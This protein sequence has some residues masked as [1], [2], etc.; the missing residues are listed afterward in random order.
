MELT[1]HLG[2]LPTVFIVAI[3]AA[4]LAMT[5]GL[6]QRTASDVYR[7]MSIAFGVS[8]LFNMVLI[9]TS[10]RNPVQWG[11]SQATL[12]LLSFVLFQW[13][14]YRFFFPRKKKEQLY[15][16]IA[17]G[18]SIVVLLVSLFLSPELGILVSSLFSLTLTILAA[19]WV[20]PQYK[21]RMKF[22]LALILFLCAALLQIVFAVAGSSVI[23]LVACLFLAAHHFTMFLLLF[24][25]IMDVI[26]AISYTSKT[27]GLTGLFLKKY[28]I[29]KTQEAIN[30]GE[31]VA[32]I[33]SDIDNF[34]TLN[35]TQGHQ[36]GDIILKHVAKIMAEVCEGVGIAGRYGGEEMVAL[37]TDPDVS[38]AELAELFRSRVEE[39]SADITPVT[40]SVGHSRYESSVTAAAEF[41]RQADEAMYK[42]K[43]RGK[44]RVVSYQVKEM[45]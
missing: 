44:N 32:V 1:A 5:L 7:F 38:P 15:F 13:G 40:V 30:S 14:V 27:D 12:S 34:K 11:S 28:F 45:E 35:D 24:D 6:Y 43:R 20:H 26:H 29:D 18:V 17:G 4:V 36:M 8:L 23:L 39:E 31:A 19:I 3:Q 42:A 9:L 2:I 33:F 25:R 10:L 41:I 16:A 21:R 37:I 22:L